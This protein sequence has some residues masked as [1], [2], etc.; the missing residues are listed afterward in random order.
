MRLFFLLV[1]MVFTFFPLYSNENDTIGQP[2]PDIQINNNYEGKWDFWVYGKIGHSFLG[3]D[4]YIFG[5][6]FMIF[7]S[8]PGK[9]GENWFFGFHTVGIDYKYQ[10]NENHS[11]S[12]FR[13]DYTYFRYFA[14][15]GGGVGISVF[16]NINNYDT[17]IAPQIGVDLFLGF[18]SISCHYRYN[19][20]LNNVLNNY[21]EI[22][23]FVSIYI[24]IK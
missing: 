22:P 24:P 2:E 7:Y 4:N 17:G 6:D 1:I 8:E 13:I 9:S 20:V 15:F 19:F 16:H 11:S 23:F 21:H 18:I 5:L 14:I 12:I 10:Y 3:D